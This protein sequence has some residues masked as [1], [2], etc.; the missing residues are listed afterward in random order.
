MCGRWPPRL[1]RDS[2]GA[3]QP[4]PVPVIG[5]VGHEDARQ[6]HGAVV[7]ASA[8]Q[9]HLDPDAHHRTRRGVDDGS[10]TVWLLPRTMT[11][12]IVRACRQDGSSAIGRLSWALYKVQL[13]SQGTGQGG[14]TISGNCDRTVLRLQR[15]PVCLDTNPCSI[16]RISRQP[17]AAS[18]RSPPASPVCSPLNLAQS[19][20]VLEH[21]GFEVD[22][23]DL[24]VQTL[25]R[26][27]LTAQAVGLSQPD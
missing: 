16:N 3:A 20:V 24:S 18:S 23:L 5:Q 14:S 25:Y 9:S 13:K 21:R 26:Q 17:K 12:L 4:M 1:T 22:V 8:A 6:G 27:E 10:S 19:K 15:L 7:P 11:V 2:A